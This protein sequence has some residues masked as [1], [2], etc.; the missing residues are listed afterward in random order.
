MEF[1]VIRTFTTILHKTLDT[2]GW[3]LL[4]NVYLKLVTKLPKL[5]TTIRVFNQV[6]CPFNS[7]LISVSSYL[8]T[9]YLSTK[10]RRGIL[11]IKKEEEG[12]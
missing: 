8:S 9:I 4:G 6:F 12:L 2:E 1:S 11:L 10:K 3:G 5:S 7:L